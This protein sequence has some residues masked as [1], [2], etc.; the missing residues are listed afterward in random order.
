MAARAAVTARSQ[1][2]GHVKHCRAIVVRSVKD[3]FSSIGQNGWPR[4]THSCYLWEARRRC[5][6]GNAKGHTMA[7]TKEFDHVPVVCRGM[8]L[9]WRKGYGRTAIQDL[10]RRIKLYRARSYNALVA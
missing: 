6:E 3:I 5:R 1:G 10:D 4:Q 2:E 9:F 8:V 7:G